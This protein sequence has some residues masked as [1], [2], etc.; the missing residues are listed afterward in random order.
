[1]KLY[2][3]DLLIGFESVVTVKDNILNTEVKEDDIAKAFGLAL[4]EVRKAQGITLRKMSEDI[5]I[6]NPTINRYEN[7]QNI[8][9]LLQAV[10]IANYFHISIEL[11]LILGMTALIENVDIGKFYQQLRYAL[12]EAKKKNIINRAR[13]K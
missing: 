5:E 8:P 11:M 3:K 7:G 6:P 1:M 4:K 10:K 9:S 2:I 13:K 12:D